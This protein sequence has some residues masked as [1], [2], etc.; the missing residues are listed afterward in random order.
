MKHHNCKAELK[1]RCLGFVSG[2][3]SRSWLNFWKEKLMSGFRLSVTGFRMLH[4]CAKQAVTFFS[5]FFLSFERNYWETTGLQNLPVWHSHKGISWN[6]APLLLLLCGTEVINELAASHI[7]GYKQD[8]L[9]QS[10][11]V[12]GGKLTP[13]GQRIICAGAGG[14]GVPSLRGPCLGMCENTHC[15][16]HPAISIQFWEL[17]LLLLLCT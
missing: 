11:I 1:S 6:L 10:G 14:W 8:P 4:E 9:H 3:I 17:Q 7:P 2:H 13:M 5:F 15:S 16:F 12:G